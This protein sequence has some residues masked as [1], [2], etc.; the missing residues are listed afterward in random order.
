MVAR[1]CAQPFAMDKTST[2]SPSFSFV[3]IVPLLL[4]E[5]RILRRL[6]LVDTF[7]TLIVG[8]FVGSAVG[9]VV[10]VAVGSG[11]GVSVGLSTGVTVGI[12]VGATVGAMVGAGVGAVAAIIL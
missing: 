10:G 4:A 6:P 2:L 9:T 12:V 8:T 7:I 5:L 3:I 1:I 11:V